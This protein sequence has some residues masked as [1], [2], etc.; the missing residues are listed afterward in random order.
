MK[1]LVPFVLIMGLLFMI[2]G[3][4]RNT[5]NAIMED[6]PSNVKYLTKSLQKELVTERVTLIVTPMN[7]GKAQ[8]VM[9]NEDKEPYKVECRTYFLG[10]GGA[11][12]DGPTTWQ[13]IFIPA[14]GTGM[15]EVL[16]TRD[17]EEIADFYIEVREVP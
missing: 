6:T 7:K 5:S 9:Y 1:R 15:Y 11:I 10:E 14:E 2:G 12:I 3:C 16:S 13:L 8:M 17:A 4:K